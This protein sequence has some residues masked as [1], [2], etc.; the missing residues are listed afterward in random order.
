MK[1]TEKDIVGKLKNYSALKRTVLL[2][3]YELE[4][5]I[6]LVTDETVSNLASQKQ[7][8]EHRLAESRLELSRLEFYIGLLP[9]EQA[10]VMRALYI[11]RERWCCVRSKYSLTEATLKRIRKNA[12]DSLVEMYK[13]TFV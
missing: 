7:H 11:E 4:N 8:L 3:N 12:I 9:E 13:I 2:L 10:M 1:L 6:P 5:S